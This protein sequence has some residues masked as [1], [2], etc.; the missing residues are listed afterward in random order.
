MI[1][2]LNVTGAWDPSL[3]FTMVGALLVTLPAFAV[4]R[5]MR[6]PL[7]TTQ[8]NWPTRGDIDARLIVGAV[9]FG[10]GWGVSGFCPGP[11]LASL[12]LGYVDSFI[13][14]GGLL[15][16]TFVV[17]LVERKRG[18]GEV[19]ISPTELEGQL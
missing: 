4:A 3:A 11:A 14:M 16:G 8:F 2:F 7:A 10:V 6:K 18:G 1:G 17:R 13:F 9:T 12:S 19:I 15:V 5:R